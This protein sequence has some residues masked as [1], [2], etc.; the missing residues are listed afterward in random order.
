MMVQLNNK[1]IF[2][3]KYIQKN[4]KGGNNMFKGQ[5]GITLV[6]LA[7][8]IAVLLILAGVTVASITSHD[9]IM[10]NADTAVN[11]YNKQASDQ[12]LAVNAMEI[13]LYNYIGIKE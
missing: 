1:V 3:N 5:N 7:I 6:A 2:I 9:S 13:L 8:T 11:Q 10:K 12:V 4:N